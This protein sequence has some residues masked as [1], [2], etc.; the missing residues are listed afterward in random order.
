MDLRPKGKHDLQSASSVPSDEV[1]S[2]P[3]DMRRYLSVPEIGPRNEVP[4][5]KRQKTGS[6]A[7]LKVRI[8]EIPCAVYM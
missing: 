5:M 3:P 1:D 7:K 8:F 4:K 6:K 2:E